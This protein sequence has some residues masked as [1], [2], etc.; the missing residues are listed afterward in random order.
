MVMV[1]ECGE[2]ELEWWW[3]DAF[4]I[5]VNPQGDARIDELAGEAENLRLDVLLGVVLLEFTA[6]GESE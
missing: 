6:D 1:V 4:A 5:A 3:Y 2:R